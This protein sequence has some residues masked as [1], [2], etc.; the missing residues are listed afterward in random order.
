VSDT[1]ALL[2]AWLEFLVVLVV[3]ALVLLRRVP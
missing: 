1:T 3:L 2:L